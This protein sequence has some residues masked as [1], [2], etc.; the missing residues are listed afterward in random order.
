QIVEYDMNTGHTLKHTIN[1]ENNDD[2]SGIEGVAYAKNLNA[3]F[4]LNEKN[5]GKLIKLRSDFSIIAEYD[6]NFASDYSGIFHENSTNNLWIVSDKNKTLNKCT[7][8]G[9][10]I[11][12]YS[13]RVTQAEGIA[14]SKDKIYV[15]SDA[16]EKLY[17][18][19]KPQ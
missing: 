12:S 1:Y 14:I 18:Y 10:L 9:D 7:L 3:I 19:K 15:V 2:N 5:P 16:E 13:I 6:L 8:K 17:I 4:I 11:E